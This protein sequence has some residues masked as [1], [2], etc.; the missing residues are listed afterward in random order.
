MISKYSKLKIEDF[1]RAELTQCTVK[2][3]IFARLNFR[4]SGA[5]S[6]LRA[7][8]FREFVMHLTRTGPYEKCRKFMSTKFSPILGYREFAQKK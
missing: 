1:L 5:P 4:K 2:H 8:H 3:F 7:L 6:N